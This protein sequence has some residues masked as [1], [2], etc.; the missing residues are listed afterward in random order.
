MCFLHYETKHRIIFIFRSDSDET[1]HYGQKI[2]SASPLIP[3]TVLPTAT[4]QQL[5]P[6]HLHTP[7]RLTSPVQTSPRLT[8]PVPVL[9]SG[10]RHRQ[11]TTK[12][13]TL[14]NSSQTLPT[15]VKRVSV[16]PELAA[17]KRRAL[18]SASQ[19]ASKN[20]SSP[21]T[22]TTTAQRHESSLSSSSILYPRYI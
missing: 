21:P 8:S 14:P 20:L 5:S 17:I 16:S 12:P 18:I 2:S 15:E 1:S 11:H 4:C 9:D 3:Y 19:A 7:P 10:I 22:K 13:K 6:Q